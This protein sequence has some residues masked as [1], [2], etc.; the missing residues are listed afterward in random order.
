MQ[1]NFSSINE[2]TEAFST[3]GNKEEDV[4]QTGEE[5]NHH[6]GLARQNDSYTCENR[7]RHRQDYDDKWLNLLKEKVVRETEKKEEDSDQRFFF[8]F[9]QTLEMYLKTES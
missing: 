9:Y 5:H 6:T 4:I 7:K 1:N 3:E 8:H 2:T